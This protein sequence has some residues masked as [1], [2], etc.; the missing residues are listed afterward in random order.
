[1]VTAMQLEI[2]KFDFDHSN[3][4]IGKDWLGSLFM[5][6]LLHFDL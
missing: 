3:I 5:D 6:T 2:L 1:M 4:F